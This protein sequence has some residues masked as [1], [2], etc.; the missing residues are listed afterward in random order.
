MGY[1]VAIDVVEAV[2]RDYPGLIGDGNRFGVFVDQVA[3]RLNR[4]DGEVRWGR[5]ARNSDGSNTN[6]DG[7]TYL[8]S[9]GDHGKKIIVDIIVNSP[10]PGFIVTSATPSWQE[11]LGD[12]SGNGFWIPP[13]H[14]DMDVSPLPPPPPPPP[15]PGPDPRID[16][17]LRRVA[18][19]EREVVGQDHSID[20]L[21]GEI[22]TLKNVLANGIQTSRAWGHAHVV[23]YPPKPRP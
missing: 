10:D 1:R 4:I 14:A 9:L 20:G 23:Q 16:D 5:K 8:N 12:N 3:H 7:L 22:M 11:Y 17:L 18:S 6:G 19:L 15:Q 2:N 21:I 13:I